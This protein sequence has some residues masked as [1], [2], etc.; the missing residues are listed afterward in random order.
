MVDRTAYTHTEYRHIKCFLFLVW[1][2]SQHNLNGISSSTKMEFNLPFYIINYSQWHRR[3]RKWMKGKREKKNYIFLSHHQRLTLV[4][5]VL[6]IHL[7][8]CRTFWNISS[9]QS[10]SCDVRNYYILL[11]LSHP[12]THTHY[13]LS[14]FCACVALLSC[15]LVITLLN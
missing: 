2:G 7:C 13:V 1:I 10:C 9:L 8:M 4:L 15:S 3:G 6:P 12:L 14:F 5:R 11:A